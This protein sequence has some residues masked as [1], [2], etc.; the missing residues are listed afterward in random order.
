[1]LVYQRVVSAVSQTASLLSFMRTPTVTSWFLTSGSSSPSGS[2]QR[3]ET[4]KSM[5]YKAVPFF[6]KR[7]PPKLV[8]CFILF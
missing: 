6:L 2:S 8:I 7:A 5:P 4:A 1:M 3:E